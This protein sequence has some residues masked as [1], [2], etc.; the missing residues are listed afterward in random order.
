MAYHDGRTT[1]LY[2]VVGHA[3]Q[4][5]AFQLIQTSRSDDD[6]RRL[7]IVDQIDEHMPCILCVDRLTLHSDV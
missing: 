5:Y 2:Q 1:F 4:N 7:D 6:Q 3:T